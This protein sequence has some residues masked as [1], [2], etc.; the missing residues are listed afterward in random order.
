MC[1]EQRVAKQVTRLSAIDESASGTME[2]RGQI[3]IKAPEG[4]VRS[5]SIHR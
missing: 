1:V 5:H 2:V 4:A 3:E